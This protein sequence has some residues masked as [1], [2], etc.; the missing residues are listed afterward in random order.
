MQ[1][2]PLTSSWSFLALHLPAY[3]PFRE[4]FLKCFTPKKP[5][6]S[7]LPHKGGVARL[8]PFVSQMALCLSAS[9]QSSLPKIR[10][11]IPLL[12][13]SSLSAFRW[14]RVSLPPARVLCQKLELGYPCYFCQFSLLYLCPPK[15]RTAPTV[16]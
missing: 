11:Q 6:L 8:V 1:D 12:S 15:T 2:T 4:C 9:C 10:A 5:S 14:L 7:P 3:E 16:W 13:L